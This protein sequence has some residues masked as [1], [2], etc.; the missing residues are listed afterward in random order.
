MLSAAALGRRALRAWSGCQG[1]RRWPPAAGRPRQRRQGRGAPR[2]REA[3]AQLPLSA[4]DP[5]H[6][7]AGQRMAVLA[8]AGRAAGVMQLQDRVRVSLRHGRHHLPATCW[9]CSSAPGGAELLG[10]LQHS[11]RAS[12]HNCCT[13]DSTGPGRTWGC[14]LWP[15]A[16]RSARA[17]A[18][19]ASTRWPG[20]AHPVDLLQGPGRH[21]AR[22]GRGRGWQRRVG[23]AGVVQHRV[24]RRSARP[25]LLLQGAGLGLRV[26]GARRLLRM[27]ASAQGPRT[28]MVG[29]P[30]VFAAPLGRQAQALLW[31]R[32]WFRV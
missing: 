21:R 15:H 6:A 5:A 27:W 8:S 30:Q 25:E 3:A 11:R 24:A 19:R 10:Q 22:L 32:A 28:R 2:W 1:R 16:A 29:A 18:R 7:A 9:P 4:P 31:G 20:R 14:V 23:R 17:H 13:T 26:L 12:L